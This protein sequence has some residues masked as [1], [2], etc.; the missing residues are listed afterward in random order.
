MVLYKR[1]GRLK[2]FHRKAR[3]GSISCIQISTLYN[4]NKEIWIQQ[5][6][7]APS[8]RVVALRV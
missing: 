7:E 1:S 2:A 8:D 5:R 4:L 3:I 6:W